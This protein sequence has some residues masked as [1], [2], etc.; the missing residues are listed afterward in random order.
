MWSG[1]RSHLR[2]DLVV[3]ITLSLLLPL[4]AAAGPSS[5]QRY[6]IVPSESQVIYRVGETLFREGNR[7]NVAVGVTN[8]VKG[9]IFVDRANPRNSR[10][11]PI[12]VDISTF[13]TDNS[14]RDNAIRERWLES[15][16]FPIAEFRPTTIQGIPNSYTEGREVSFQVTGEL[17]IRDVTRLTTFSVTVKLEGDRLMGTATGTIRMTDFGF[18]PPSIF[19]ILRAENEVQ[20]E[21][22]FVARAAS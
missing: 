7:Y 18:E 20:I 9:E 10:V 13:R 11:G 3:T 8:A 16:R 6:V 4:I 19:G 1:A 14:R 17:K 2:I 22:K 12:T 21:F 15:A 5:V